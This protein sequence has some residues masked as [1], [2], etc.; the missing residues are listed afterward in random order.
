MPER[1]SRFRH[2]GETTDEWLD[3]LRRVNPYAGDDVDRF[4]EMIT[5]IEGEAEEAAGFRWLSRETQNRQ[6]AILKKSQDFV[7]RL[8]KLPDDI[9]DDQLEKACFHSPK[10]GDSGRSKWNPLRRA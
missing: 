6:E 5:E 10:A 8:E 3:R 9:T 4:S 7:K 1:P 2:R